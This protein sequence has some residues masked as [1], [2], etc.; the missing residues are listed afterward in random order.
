MHHKIIGLKKLTFS[1]FIIIIGLIVLS[2][3]NNGV[4]LE[5]GIIG[6]IVTFIYGFFINSLFK[7]VEHK[8]TEFKRNLGIL[9]AN[10]Q[11]LYNMVLLSNDNKLKDDV[12]QKLVKLIESI[13]NLSP[14]KYSES[15]D[16]VNDLFCAFNGY[17]IRNKAEINLHS[18]I[19][20]MLCSISSSREEL[21]IFGYRYLIGGIKFLFIIFPFLLAIIILTVTKYNAYL[22]IV[23]IVLIAVLIVTSV[24][25]L[26]MDSL[27]YGDYNINKK[28]LNQLLEFLEKH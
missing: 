22:M 7:F 27:S 3:L 18:R 8:Y 25:L 12:K 21:E 28:N 17:R 23:G 2:L 20:Q 6:S 15:Q 16:M 24:L 13:K 11:S 19:L 1:I 5:L 26:D 4:S 9:S 10:I 14:E